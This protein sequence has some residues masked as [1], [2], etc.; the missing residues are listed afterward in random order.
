MMLGSVS[1]GPCHT[2]LTSFALMPRD[3]PRI[4]VIGGAGVGKSRL[5]NKIA[6]VYYKWIFDDNDSSSS[7]SDSDNES[8]KTRKPTNEPKIICEGQKPIFGV[9][10]THTTSWAQVKF[11]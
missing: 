10:T 4:L 3:I 11:F 7:E 8:N 9:N 5:C 1:K 6:G 2:D